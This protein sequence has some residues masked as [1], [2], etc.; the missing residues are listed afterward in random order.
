M[1]TFRQL[2]E[3]FEESAKT[4]AAKGRRFEDF[5]A[6]FLRIDRT[7]A[8][9]FDEV[10]TWEDWPG[11]PPGHP[12]TGIDLVARERGTG[13]LVAIQCKFYRPSA[14]LG[15][16]HISTF[17]AMLS[18]DLFSSG[19]V[20]STAGAE[21]ANLHK[22][23]AVSPKQVVWWRVDDF[24]ESLVDWN[25]FRPA[26]PTRLFLGEVKSLRPHQESAIADVVQGLADADRG[27]LVMACGTGKTF[28]SLRLAE[29]L[30]GK[31]GS[32]LFLVPSINLLSQSVIAWAN[33]A[34]VPLTTFAVCSDTHAGRRGDEDMSSNDLQIPAST[35]VDGLI[36]AV[37][38]QAEP[39]RMTAVFSTY[40]SIDVIS[41]A[42]KA[43]L[44]RFDLIICDEA[45]RTTGSFRD[46]GD[47]SMFTKVHDDAI[48]GADK[49]LYMTATPRVYGDQTK[50]K[51]KAADVIVASMDDT[52]RFGEVLHNL[53][54]G[55]AVADELLTDYKVL[56]LAVNEDSVSDAFQRQFAESGNE[57]PLN[58]VARMVGCWHGLSKRGPQFDGDGVPHASSG[59]VLVDDQAVE[60][61]HDR[62]P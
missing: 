45:H 28:T 35:D 8:E 25:A 55:K 12:D 23:I 4:Q 7:W 27:Q 31:G 30:V 38:L 53:P 60:E 62:L 56:V 24:E 41:D 19:M 57:L 59:G 11:R 1:T 6:A 17:V 49:R 33:D 32:V 47:Q 39:T 26:E 54:F 15:W 51:A 52:S 44:G 10:W 34:Q 18:Q 21:S 40:Q 22:N 16:E 37:T 14:V 58:D 61:V 5:C 13:A 42:Q 48:V 2:L 9:K 43:G 50:A 20:I 46:A 36:N 3:F 29:Q